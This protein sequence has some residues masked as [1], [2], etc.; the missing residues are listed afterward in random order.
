M[1]CLPIK[2]TAAVLLITIAFGCNRQPKKEPITEEQFLATR[3]KMIEV[4]KIL[5]KKDEQRIRGYIERQGLTMKETETGLWYQIEDKGTGI[6]AER[7]KIARIAYKV[8]LLDGTTCYSSEK[9]GIKE[10]LIGKGG[11]ESGLEEGILLMHVGGK[12]LFILPPHLAY[13]LPGDGNC[14]PARAII[15]YHVE[16]LSLK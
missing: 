15:Q 9:D 6:V 2:I 5:L 13:G 8:D 3:K 12:A 10:F 1:N 14:I 4:N 11:V 7:G 16:L